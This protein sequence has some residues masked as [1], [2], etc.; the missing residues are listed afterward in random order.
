[1]T[2]FFLPVVN[3]KNCYYF[4]QVFKTNYSSVRLDVIE[5]FKTC[6]KLT[7]WPEWALFCGTVRHWLCA[8]CTNIPRRV[9]RGILFRKR[10]QNLVLNGWLRLKKNKNTLWLARTLE[11]EPLLSKTCTEIWL[12]I[13]CTFFRGRGSDP[14]IQTINSAMR[15]TH[16]II[17]RKWLLHWEKRGLDL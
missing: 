6:C 3:E 7:L 14:T 1:M 12:P 4:K 17:C 9:W 2:S 10:N 11:N 16:L 8:V 5:F 13:S 15:H